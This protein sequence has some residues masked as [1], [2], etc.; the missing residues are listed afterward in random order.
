MNNI[1]FYLLNKLHGKQV[2]SKE[3]QS[4]LYDYFVSCSATL[5]VYVSISEDDFKKVFKII[6]EVLS[7]Y[8][9]DHE[10]A[11]V[12]ENYIK[13]LLADACDHEVVDLKHFIDHIFYLCVG[14]QDKELV[15]VYKECVPF[16]QQRL[17]RIFNIEESLKDVAARKLY[18]RVMINCASH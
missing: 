6:Y 1:N 11:E 12:S 8:I 2:L 14:M 9:D 10:F 7:L 5:D 3:K 4:A 16:I 17:I 15:Q 13:L 18:T